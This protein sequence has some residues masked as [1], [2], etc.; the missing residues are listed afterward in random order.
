[1]EVDADFAEALCVLEQVPAMDLDWAAMTRDTRAALERMPAVR[2]A[3][4]ATFD[5]PT[6]AVLEARAEALRGELSPREAYRDIPA[7]RR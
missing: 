5:R 7:G 3:F 4:L 2:E 1:M 6:R